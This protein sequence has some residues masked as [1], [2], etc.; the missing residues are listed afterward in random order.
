MEYRVNKFDFY[1]DDPT[2]VPIHSK[3]K[4]ENDVD[5]SS[6]ARL[7]NHTEQNQNPTVENHTIPIDDGSDTDSVTLMGF[8]KDIEQIMEYK[9][10]NF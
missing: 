8:D 2:D 10:S 9:E 6:E 3:S 5:Q 1:D 7:K 4:N